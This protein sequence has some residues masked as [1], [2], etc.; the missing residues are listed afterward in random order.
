MNNI[1]ENIFN[2][3][4]YIPHLFWA[5]FL[6]NLIF[7]TANLFVFKKTSNRKKFI[8]HNIINIGDDL[9]ALAA[10]QLRT[11]A[12]AVK[13]Y[14]IMTLDGYGGDLNDEQRKLLL[15]ALDS[16]ERQLR[17]IT[18]LLYYA[19]AK[20][21]KLELMKKDIDINK[22]IEDAV[23]EHKILIH[24]NNHKL[25]IKFCSKKIPYYGDELFLKMAISNLL[26]NAIKYT[27]HGGI[28]QISTKK[29]V[30]YFE[31]DIN[32][33]GVG[34]EQD[35]FKFLFKQFSRIKNPLSRHRIGSGL[36]LFLTARIIDLH[37]GKISLKSDVK[38]GSTFTIML[39]KKVNFEAS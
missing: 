1:I 36:G 12:T 14:I 9:L 29:S 8:D 20:A 33:N 21:G 25:V 22:L 30:D 38:I 27:R 31:I 35:Q 15:N 13:Q 37:H 5:L 2:Y 4:S 39:P 24:E 23:K 19:S 26:S 16:N 28:I 32:D 34:I 6:S 17:T 10:H 7:I 11:P 18:N 3:L